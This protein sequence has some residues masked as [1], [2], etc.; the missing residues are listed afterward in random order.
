MLAVWLS[1]VRT[2]GRL[3]IST[4]FRLASAR[5]S[6]LRFSEPAWRSRP[7]KP[8]LLLDRAV[9]NPVPIWPA[10]E[11]AFTLGEVLFPRGWPLNRKPG[12]FD[13]D[14]MVCE[15]TV[16]PGVR[17]V[18]E[19]VVGAVVSADRLNKIESCRPI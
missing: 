2:R 12:V 10:T 17:V 8:R 16:P 5:S 7:G 13:W 14:R 18:V 11:L 19:T 1:T 4:R 15:E 9:A 6:R 3:R